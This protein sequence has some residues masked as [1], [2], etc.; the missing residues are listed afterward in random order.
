[1][2]RS[3]N[4]AGKKEGRISTTILIHTAFRVASEQGRGR[5]DNFSSLLGREPTA[6]SGRTLLLASRKLSLAPLPIEFRKG[7][8]CGQGNRRFH[9][10]CRN[11]RCLR[12]DFSPSRRSGFNLAEALQ[13]AQ[14]TRRFL[15]TV[16]FYS[17]A[18]K[19][20]RLGIIR[21]LETFE[22]EQK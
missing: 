22:N 7:L 9:N 21:L 4:A 8:I 3:K 10:F 2:A 14:I 13:G 1:V 16:L 15:S 18:I 12:R 5:R 20:A 11:A 17:A 19:S 6:Q